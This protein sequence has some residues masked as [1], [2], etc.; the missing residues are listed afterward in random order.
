MEPDTELQ[1]HELASFA[2][3]HGTTEEKVRELLAQSGSRSRRELEEALEF[4]ARRHQQDVV[5][6]SLLHPLDIAGFS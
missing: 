2:G 1:P 6:R 4:Y 5:F 3:K